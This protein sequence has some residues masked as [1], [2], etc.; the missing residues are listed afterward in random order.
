MP[1]GKICPR[2]VYARYNIAQVSENYAICLL[3]GWT[4]KVLYATGGC[5]AKA[6]Q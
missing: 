3:S 6:L 5:H 2:H 1:L 4:W